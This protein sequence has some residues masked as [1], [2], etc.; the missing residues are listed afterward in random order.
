[1]DCSEDSYYYQDLS[2]ELFWSESDDE[3]YD[4]RRVCVGCHCQERTCEHLMPLKGTVLWGSEE[5][6][7]QD[8]VDL[9]E[10]LLTIG[11]KLYY[12]CSRCLKCDCVNSSQVYSNTEGVKRGLL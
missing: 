3:D 7:V 11:V 2:E 10:R 1:M 12:Q 8:Y 5:F 6:D 4:S 9:N